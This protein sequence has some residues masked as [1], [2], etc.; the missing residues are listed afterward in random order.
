MPELAAAQARFG[1]A[2]ADDAHTDLAVPLFLG[3][4]ARVRK[5]L[6]IYRGNVTANSARA[7]A[8]A[9]PIIHKLVGDE[10]FVGLASAYGRAHPSV[11]GDLNELGAQLAEFLAT[12]PPA[13]ALPYL[14]DV[15]RLEWLVHRAHYA[16]DHAP[17]DP[18]RVH[19]IA[20]CDYPRL[21]LV[22]HPAV[23]TLA[24]TYPIY[25]IWE[26]HQDDYTGEVAVDLDSGSQR[27]AVFRPAYRV[28][29]AMLSVGEMA[30]LAAI[31][32]GAQLT[33]ATDAALAAEGSF[34]LGASLR[35]WVAANII[36]DFDLA[37]R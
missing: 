10:F 20:Q 33:M 2:L 16:A 3:E 29:V 12:F 17:L 24:S 13:Q 1:A 5:R 26:V 6:A 18:G 36:V 4:A 21:S 9:Y 8:A 34:D 7:L 32:C 35:R 11:S 25:R 14:P 19:D 22:L 30:F 23:S 37:P 27:V 28:T 15:A 31:E